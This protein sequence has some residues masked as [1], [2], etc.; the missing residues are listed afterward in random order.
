M[1]RLLGK[2]MCAP[3]LPLASRL[4]LTSLLI[5]LS[6][7]RRRSSQAGLTLAITMSPFEGMGPPWLASRLS[8]LPGEFTAR[9]QFRR[10]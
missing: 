9:S 1:L 7:R 6:V 4:P 3:S 5:W 10:V 8:L 2:S